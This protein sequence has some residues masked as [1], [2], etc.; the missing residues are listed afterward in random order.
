MEYRD[1][2]DDDLDEDVYLDD[3]ND[4]EDDWDDLSD[5]D[6]GNAVYFGLDDLD[7]YADET[8][9]PSCESVNVVYLGGDNIVNVSGPLMSRVEFYQCNDC[10][11]KFTA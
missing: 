3:E 7:D 2:P 11:H 9:C 1:L 8:E 6:Y 4:E 10:G 5:V